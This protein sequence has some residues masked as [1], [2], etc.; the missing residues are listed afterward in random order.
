MTII[1]GA[2]DYDPI[3]FGVVLMVLVGL[4]MLLSPYRFNPRLA[5]TYSTGISYKKMITGVL[6]FAILMIVLLIFLVAFPQ[7][8]LWLP[9][10]L[11]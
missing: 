8:A 5:S 9:G 7:I 11:W 1:K 4:G 10:L 3:W 2:L 6:P